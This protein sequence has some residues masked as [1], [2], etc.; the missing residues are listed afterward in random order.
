MISTKKLI[1]KIIQNI[2]SSMALAAYPIGSFYETSDSTFNPN[3]EWGGTWSLESAGLVHVSA[4]TGYSIGSTG[5]AATHV[6]ATKNHALSISQMP[7]HTHNSRTLVGTMRVMAWAN[8]AVSGI[9]SISN[10]DKNK[11]PSS[12][13]NEGAATYTINATHTHDSVGGSAGHNHGNTESAT[14]FP[15]YIVVNRWHRTA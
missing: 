14:N 13:S 12:G 7:A 4:G 6:H 1:Y 15:P 2:N 5:G 3:E 10:Q 8:S 11:N 9:V